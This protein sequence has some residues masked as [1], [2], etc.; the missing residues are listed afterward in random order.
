MAVGEK[1]YNMKNFIS[2]T[3]RVVALAHDRTRCRS[4]AHIQYNALTLQMPNEY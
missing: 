3:E 1:I 2:L 4:H